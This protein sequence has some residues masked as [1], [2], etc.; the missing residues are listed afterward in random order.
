MHMGAKKTTNRH[1]HTQ[2]TT[3]VTTIIKLFEALKLIH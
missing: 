1:T 2:G 3:T